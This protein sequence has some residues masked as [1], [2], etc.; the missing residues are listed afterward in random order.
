MPAVEQ[1]PPVAPERLKLG[2]MLPTWTTS[3]VRWSEILEIGS[4]AAEVGFD[5]LY[6]SDHLLLP[7]NNA[8]MKRRAGVDFPDDPQIE[9]E[10]YL[11]CF[12]VLAALAVAIPTVALGSMVASTGYRNPGLVAKMAV[13]IDDISGGRL[14][15]GLGSGDSEGEH[16]TFGFP[17]EQRVGRFEE[18][19]QSTK[20]LFTEESTDFDG[21]H[22]RLRGARLL[23]KGPRQGG[24][25]ILIGTLN[26]QSRMRRLVA[27][28]ADIWN[29]WLGYTDASPDSAAT[30]LRI[31]DDACREHGRDPL[32]LVATT[33]VRGA[34]PGS[35]YVPRADER[36][37][38]GP[39]RE[40]AETLRGH[41][42]LGISE[43]QVALTMAGT[44]GVRAFAPVIEELRGSNKA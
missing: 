29:G 23:P 2:L 16:L 20:G 7:S 26:P 44:A 6:A 5:S 11:E 36:P 27:Q 42:R 24:P 3:D 34:M 38:S 12:T 39:P 21:T 43:V 10:G 13:T 35:G 25:P 33:A 28:Y 1:R 37:L 18:A 15:L 17:H 31:I 22:H 30:Q 8:E 9:L 4:L 19:L 32:T 14:V 41:A 40:M